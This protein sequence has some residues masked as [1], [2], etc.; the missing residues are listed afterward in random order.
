LNIATT[1]PVYD[2][3]LAQLHDLCRQA[4][5]KPVHAER[6]NAWLFRHGRRDLSS[7]PELPRPLA[8]LLQTHVNCDLPLLLQQQRSTDGTEKYLLR[9][10]DGEQVET[11]MIPGDG[12]VTQCISTQ[13]GCALGCK[14]CLTAT[15]GLRRN[16]QRGE[17]VAQLLT[18]WQESGQCARNVV[19]M[20]M[21]EPMHNFDAVAEFVRLITDP[22]GFAFS[23]RHVTLSTVGVVPGI[24]RMIEAQLPC[25][26]AISLNATTDEVR[27]C[28]MPVNRKYP[29]AVL[30][31]AMRDFA[32]AFPKRRLL[33]A[34]VLLAG[35]NDSVADAKRLV[36][37]L[38]GI[39][40]TIN[41]LPFNPWSGAAWQ[42]P[43]DG[44]ISQFRA[45]LSEA[46]LVAV[47]REPRGRDIDA[48]CGQLLHR[49]RTDNVKN[50]VNQGV[51]YA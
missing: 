6:L 8:N 4:G 12:R 9:L 32:Q 29:L 1:T 23:P 45:V 17:M 49:N 2:L 26:L 16:L 18:G 33:I 19:L 47:V 10:H 3:T 40:C 35:L 21:G 28:L 38:H 48:A 44:V 50:E 13:A 37:L 41:L 24:M 25:N 7:L 51:I 15:G 14:F 43:D 42:R 27:D 30:L 11:V 34:Y 36:T 31:A 20:G 46:G 22:A 5:A 39:P